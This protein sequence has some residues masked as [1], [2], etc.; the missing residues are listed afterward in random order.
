MLLP[1]VNSEPSLAQL[2]LISYGDL[3]LVTV[4]VPTEGISY[5]VIKSHTEILIN[6]PNQHFF[7]MSYL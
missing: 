6:Y 3:I 2:P 4:T 1:P 7:L 5:L